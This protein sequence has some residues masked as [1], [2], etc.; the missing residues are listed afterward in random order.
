MLTGKG[1]MFNVVF[2]CINSD[3]LIF[4]YLIPNTVNINRYKPHEVRF[5]G[6]FSHF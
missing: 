5:F 3:I 2:K 4:F 1:N 6:I